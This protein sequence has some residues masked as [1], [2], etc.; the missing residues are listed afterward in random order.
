IVLL[1][2][3]PPPRAFAQAPFAEESPLKTD[4]REAIFRYM[5]KTYNYGAYVK[6]YCIQPERILPER[7]LQRFSAEKIPVIW[8]TDC[9]NGG[10]MN[11]IR[12]KKT[13]KPGMRMTILSLR[14][15]RG[16][17]AEAE[18]DAFSD[19]IA[20]NWNTLRLTRVGSK[21]VV[22]VDKLTSVS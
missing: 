17:E 20:A 4:L 5:F 22:T 8:A 18:V 10:P 6:V 13:G 2:P 7:F 9:D 14:M 16:D 3:L 11:S 21:W 12:E 1:Q 19:G 15:I